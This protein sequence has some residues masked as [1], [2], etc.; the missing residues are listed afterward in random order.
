MLCYAMLW[1]YR[2]IFSHSVHG[3]RVVTLQC[4]TRLY[5]LGVRQHIEDNNGTPSFGFVSILVLYNNNENT[6]ICYM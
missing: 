2:I 1:G 6:I 3:L 5:G 4:D